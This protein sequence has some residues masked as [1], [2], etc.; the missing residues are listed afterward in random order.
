MLRKSNAD[1]EPN[2]DSSQV[3]EQ[4]E[5]DFYLFSHSTSHK[6]GGRTGE[7]DSKPFF[8]APYLS[9]LHMRDSHGSSICPAIISTTHFLILQC[10]LLDL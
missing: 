7:G 2:P 8:F 1:K 4:S 6:D 9:G 3:C 10:L 5:P